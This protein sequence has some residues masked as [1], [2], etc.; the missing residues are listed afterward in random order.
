MLKSML[1]EFL[2]ESPASVRET[3][4][5]QLQ[6]SDVVDTTEV[7]LIIQ[8]NKIKNEQDPEKRQ[9]LEKQYDDLKK[10]SKPLLLYSIIYSPY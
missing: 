8:E 7:P 9:T 3:Y 2:G 6:V 5:F 10:V 1:S 4:M